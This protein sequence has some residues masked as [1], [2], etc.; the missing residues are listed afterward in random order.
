MLMGE[1]SLDSQGEERVHF[2]VYSMPRIPVVPMAAWPELL[3]SWPFS[4]SLTSISLDV[5]FAEAWTVPGFLTACCRWPLATFSRWSMV[6]LCFLV[7]DDDGCHQLSTYNI[8]K[9]IGIASLY[10]AIL[11]VYRL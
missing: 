10:I 4:S 3:Q 8:V 6:G 2:V 7:G 1:E 9:Y 11:L 5:E